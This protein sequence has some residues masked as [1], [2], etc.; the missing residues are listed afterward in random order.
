MKKALLVILFIVLACAI[1][2]ACQEKNAAEDGC[3]PTQNEES[4]TETNFETRC[5]EAADMTDHG[6]IKIN[7]LS[8]AERNYWEQYDSALLLDCAGTAEAAVS[9]TN[10]VLEQYQ[11]DGLFRDYKP[12]LV[13]FQENP[14]VWIVHYWP[15][16]DLPQATFSIAIR[17]DTAEVV[18]MWVGE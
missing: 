18:K 1:L 3:S 15:D 8:D 13:E 7:V 11:E 9:I 17:K 10:I 4:S 12:K 2:T 5:V 16:K 6:Q 14:S